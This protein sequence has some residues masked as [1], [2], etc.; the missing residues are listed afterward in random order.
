[1]YEQLEKVYLLCYS[2]LYRYLIR[3]GCSA[4]NVDDVI[5]NT[6]LEALKHMEQYEGKAALKT[7]LFAIARYQFYHYCRKNKL[8]VKLNDQQAEQHS[9]HHDYTD[10]LLADHIVDYINSLPPPLQDIMRL[11]LLHGLSFREIGQA[12]GQSENYCRVNY[13]R[14][15]ERIRKEYQDE[16]L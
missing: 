6:F 7:W 14:I 11:R 2:E 12:V 5:Q 10:K 16:Q 8:H 9:S 15:K 4:D 3:L 13:Y 1:M